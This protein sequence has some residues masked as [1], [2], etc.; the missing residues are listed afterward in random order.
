MAP[1]S[2]YFQMGY[3]CFGI[4]YFLFLIIVF[5]FAGIW[6]LI[7]ILPIV[8]FI[9]SRMLYD[10]ENKIYEI[11]KCIPI[12]MFNPHCLI[13]GTLFALSVAIVWW[14]DG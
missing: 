7:W 5:R 3:C 14:K 6:H 10:V 1:L 13:P 8:I 2:S 9:Q 12:L 11:N 4:I